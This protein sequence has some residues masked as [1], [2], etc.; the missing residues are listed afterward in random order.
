MIRKKT[1]EQLQAESRE[2]Q[3]M[4]KEQARAR[5]KQQQQQDSKRKKHMQKHLAQL[6]QKKQEK[7]ERLQD[8]EL[9]AINNRW[10]MDDE[11]ELYSK[12]ELF[13]IERLYPNEKG[14]LTEYYWELIRK[15]EHQDWK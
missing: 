15:F 14:R 3:A 8:R 13:N 1:L 11:I 12:D 7:R 9:R 4:L 10:W 5:K 6:D 2:R